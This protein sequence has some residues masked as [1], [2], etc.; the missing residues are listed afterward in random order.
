MKPF[1]SLIRPQNGRLDKAW[2]GMFTRDAHGIYTYRVYIPTG[3]RSDTPVPLVVMLHGCSQSPEEFALT[4]DMN[5]YAEQ[6]TFLV[7]YPDQPRSSHTLKC[8]NWYQSKHQGRDKGEPARIVQ[9]VQQVIHAYAIDTNRIYVA[10]L[11]AGA[12]MSSILGATYP[13][14]F[15]AIGICSGV[16]YQAA[17]NF[18]GTLPAMTQA[19]YDADMLGEAAFKAMDSRKRVVPVVVFHGTGDMT[20]APINADKVIAQW[21]HTNQLAAKSFLA[22]YPM[23]TK[24]TQTIQDTIPSGRSYIMYS[25]EDEHGLPVMKKYLVKGMRHAWSGGPK[26]AS[27]TDPK[28]PNASALL[29]DFFLQHTMSDIPVAAPTAAPVDVAPE[30]PSLIEA[31]IEATPQPT[32]LTRIRNCVRDT[33]AKVKRFVRGLWKK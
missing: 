15:T 6:H 26:D 24:P 8:W 19:Q 32:L 11:S 30:T 3:Y 22:S 4:T 1:S 23:P 17:T 21:S 9:M 28:G 25:Y 20:V 16:P 33:G 27:F 29:V 12:A 7:L 18:A 14:I 2:P 5:T 10:G 31:T 13:D